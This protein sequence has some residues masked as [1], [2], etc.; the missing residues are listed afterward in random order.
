MTGSYR[1]LVKHAN[2]SSHSLSTETCSR[3]DLEDGKQLW[4][5][6]VDDGCQHITLLRLL[7]L[8]LACQ[9]SQ[10]QQAPIHMGM[11]LVTCSHQYWMPASQLAALKPGAST[12][13]SVQA[14]CC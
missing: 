2:P 7:E 14:G 6:G 10:R 8:V 13:P 3:S 5:G 11:I 12:V 9:H 1:A 4:E